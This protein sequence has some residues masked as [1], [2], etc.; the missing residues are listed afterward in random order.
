M[1][2]PWSKRH[3]A[4]PRPKG[5]PGDTQCDRTPASDWYII[6][7]SCIA[8]PRTIT[9]DMSN[10][11]HLRIVDTLC[12]IAL[13]ILVTIL[14]S[15]CA[16]TNKFPRPDEQ[17]LTPA[18]LSVQ[19]SEELLAAGNPELALRKVL[20]ALEMNPDLPSAY[21]QAGR[22][23]AQTQQPA[24]AD[25]YYRRAV[26]LDPENPKIRIEYGTSLCRQKR[27]KEGAEQFLMA[28][29]NHDS[30]V[31]AIAY[32]N[33]GLCA[34]RASDPDG[35]AQYFRAA[36]EAEPEMPVPYYQLASI[37][38]GKGRYIQARRY[39]QGYMDYGTPTPKALLLGVRI[40][41]ASGDLETYAR[42]AK[43]LESGFPYSEEAKLIADLPAPRSTPT[44][45]AR[46]A[47]STTTSARLSDLPAEE[48]VLAQDP[49]HYTIQL[50]RSRNRQALDYVRKHL[51]AATR[52]MAYYRSTSTGKQW[53]GLVYGV[54]PNRHSAEAAFRGLPAPIHQAGALIRPF[55]SVQRAILAAPPS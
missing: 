18:Q 45:S 44:Q 38:Y 9:Q 20:Q 29:Q 34:L 27:P 26:H 32:T 31:K 3:C 37:N 46:A 1:V 16:S 14:L 49:D 51:K 7:S 48:W 40:G 21:Q 22:I 11:D 36:L 6:A 15:A 25:K 19:S 13:S 23:Y 28:A 4:A 43:L 47:A 54:F 12:L 33:A 39:L 42:Y 41:R 8:F 55:S 17:R 50:I 24:L 2:D 30:H 35:A 10:G 5:A 53:Y 52:P